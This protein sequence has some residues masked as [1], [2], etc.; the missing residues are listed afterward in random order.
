LGIDKL[1]LT[2]GGD[3]VDGLSGGQNGTSIVYSMNHS[4]CGA[5]KRKVD[6]AD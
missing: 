1:I 5:R 2:F 4:F 6:A 3:G